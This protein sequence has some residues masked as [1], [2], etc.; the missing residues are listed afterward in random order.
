MRRESRN[1]ST[2]DFAKNMR[3]VREDVAAALRHA[4]EMMKEHHD[5]H[6]R[7]AGEYKEGEKVYLENTNLRTD[8]PSKKLDD[9]VNGSAPSKSDTKSDLQPTNSN[10]PLTGLQSI[11]SL[12]NPI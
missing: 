6:A 9:T 4:V 5:W 8:R 10:Y 11:Q 12:M 3:T 1:E 2:E 7:P